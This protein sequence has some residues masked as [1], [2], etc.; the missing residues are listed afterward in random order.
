MA[1]A[2][3]LEEE[4]RRAYEATRRARVASS[5]M[6][7]EEGAFGPKVKFAS[8]AD[9]ASGGPGAGVDFLDPR[10]DAHD[11]GR[12]WG[13]ADAENMSADEM[14]PGMVPGRLQSETA[15]W[16]KT[17]KGQKTAGSSGR[18]EAAGGSGPAHKAAEGGHFA[19]E[20]RPLD[21]EEAE[22]IS[23]PGGGRMKGKMPLFMT[24]EGEIVS[25]H[26]AVI[27]GR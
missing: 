7:T 25:K 17:Q 3:A 6:G 21:G 16:Q 2:V 27:T 1:L 14:V 23:L 15:R 24:A 20:E 18:K 13:A 22:C 5:K 4:E 26:D 8:A 11:E 9:F 19:A 12:R 10:D